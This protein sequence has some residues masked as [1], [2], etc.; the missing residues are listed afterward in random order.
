M[1]FL[2]M[3]GDVGD[4]CHITKRAKIDVISIVSGQ[5]YDILHPSIAQLLT[6]WPFPDL[7]HIMHSNF[8]FEQGNKMA[9]SK[10]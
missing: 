1:T 7:C 6:S 9:T 5:N 8:I 10:F 2:S 4:V 3:S